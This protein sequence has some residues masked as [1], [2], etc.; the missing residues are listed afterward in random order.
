MI[1]LTGG[2]TSSLLSFEFRGF[3]DTDHIV[4]LQCSFDGTNY[5]KTNCASQSEETQSSFPGS[6]GVQRNYNVK[7]GKAYRQVIPLLFPKTYF[8]GVKVLND[9]NELSPAVTWTFKMRAMNDAPLVGEREGTPGLEN[10]KKIK[11]I[12]VHFDSIKIN[13]DGDL[14]SGKYRV[15]NNGDIVMYKKDF[16]TETTTAVIGTPK[17]PDGTLNLITGFKV[18]DPGEWHLWAFVQ[19]KIIDLLQRTVTSPTNL[20]FVGKQ[21]TLD[22]REDVPLSIFTF[23]IESDFP[24]SFNT[25]I[26]CKVN[27]DQLT[28]D[29][30]QIFTFPHSEWNDRIKKLETGLGPFKYFPC[31]GGEKLPMDKEFLTEKQPL[32]I[33]LGPTSNYNLHITITTK[34]IESSAAT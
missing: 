2:K 29:V 15:C 23:G 5:K 19:G 31:E 34:M 11:R 16:S 32:D 24:L 7:S 33:V 9:K 22:I 26:Q 13:Q 30:A 18:K 6:D 12:T 21:I 25:L 20:Q 10:V 28:K 14:D 27:R 4:E 8:F 1:T 3:D 17:C